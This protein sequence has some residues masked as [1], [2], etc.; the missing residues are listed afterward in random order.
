MNV[1]HALLSSYKA[2][3]AI[4][5]Q[6]LTSESWREGD[7]V[8]SEPLHSHES[9]EVRLRGELLHAK[10]SLSELQQIVEDVCATSMGSACA[11]Q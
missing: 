10:R 11:L 9:S 5:M 2:T 4:D 7:V 6:L 3:D 1:L 8:D